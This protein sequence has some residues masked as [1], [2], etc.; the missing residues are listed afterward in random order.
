M[1][2]LAIYSSDRVALRRLSEDDLDA[3]QAYRTDVEVWKY[4]GWNIV[5]DGEA[6]AFLKTVAH[7]P[8]LVPSEWCQ[9][10]IALKEDNHL[11]GDIGIHVS[12]SQD[13]A[14][15]GFS[16]NRNY[17]GKGLASEAVVLAMNFIFENSPVQKIIGITDA[18]N[19]AS[20]RLLERLK[21]E[22][23]ESLETE[24]RGE[25]CIEHTYVITRSDFQKS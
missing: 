19:D 5:S 20:I 3:F 9:I 11:I 10:A 7:F 6:R 16:L 4:Q 24:F 2:D 22:K 17:Q 13:Q 23:L 18:R 12:E 14:E 8:L 25:P 1:K 15:I 21:M